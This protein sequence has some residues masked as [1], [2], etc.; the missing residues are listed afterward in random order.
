MQHFIEDSAMLDGAAPDRDGAAQDKSTIRRLREE[1]RA[2]NYTLSAAA[3]L[4]STYGDHITGDDVA[5]DHLAYM[6]REQAEAAAELAMSD[7]VSVR[8]RL[9]RGSPRL[10]C[11]APRPG[12]LRPKPSPSGQPDQAGSRASSAS[13]L[14][15]DGSLSV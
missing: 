9:S 6:E 15:T 14:E 13:L 5:L 4:G 2:D 8:S 3:G 10:S 12:D 7:M 1:A 11:E